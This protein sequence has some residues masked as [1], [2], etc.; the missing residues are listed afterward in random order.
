MNNDRERLNEAANP[1]GETEGARRATGVSPAGGAAAPQALA[2]LNNRPD[3][4]V[5]E[6]PTRRKFNA[7]QKLKIVQEAD[8]CTEYGEI[9]ALLRREGI[10]ASQLSE[11]RKQRDKGSL[12]ALNPAKRGRKGK[13]K[14]P[15]ADEVTRLERENRKLK[16]SLEKA[17]LIIDF[18]KKIA[19][20]LDS[21]LDQPPN[22]E[23]E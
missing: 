5:P 7:A 18:Q 12:D 1:A 21:P 3:P 14:N 8:Q 19:A 11:W 6:K 15:L 22:I 20:L 4:E 10:Y 2:R 17:E 9:G 16:K 23:D 13:A